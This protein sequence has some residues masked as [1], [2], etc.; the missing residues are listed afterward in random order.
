M[1]IYCIQPLN[2]VLLYQTMYY[3][4]ET[5]IVALPALD[6]HNRI[7]FSWFTYTSW[8]LEWRCWINTWITTS[9]LE[10][11]LCCSMQL[12]S[13]DIL[14]LCIATSRNVVADHIW[15]VDQSTPWLDEIQMN[16]LWRKDSSRVKRLCVCLHSQ[17]WCNKNFTIT[18]L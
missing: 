12:P 15:W 5:I 8:M 17:R 13:E 7:E 4:A 6:L 11:A 14:P 16:Y 2:S 10:R 18:K 3:Q 1:T 9:I